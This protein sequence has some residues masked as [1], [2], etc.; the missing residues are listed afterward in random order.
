MI[1]LTPD[2]LGTIGDLKVA[3]QGWE[4]PKDWVVEGMCLEAPKLTFHN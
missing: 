4:Y 2:G 3:Y 1:R